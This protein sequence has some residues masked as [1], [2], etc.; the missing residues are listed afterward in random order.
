VQGTSWKFGKE[1]AAKSR[2]PPAQLIAGNSKRRPHFIKSGRASAALTTGKRLPP[3]MTS[4]ASSSSPISRPNRDD[5]QAAGTALGLFPDAAYA[6]L[7]D[8]GNAVGCSISFRKM[9]APFACYRNASTP[10]RIPFSRILSP[11]TTATR[12]PS[13]NSSRVADHRLVA[14][15]KQM[16]IGDLGQRLEPRT[17]PACQ[18]DPLHAFPKRRRWDKNGR[19]ITRTLQRR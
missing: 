5:R 16:L 14:A 4:A 9:P 18:Y 17:Q 13:A 8:F 19:K 11:S 15:G 2:L 1:T 10:G 7:L 6:A 3:S 12:S